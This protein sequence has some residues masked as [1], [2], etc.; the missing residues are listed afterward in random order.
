MV[1]TLVGVYVVT[2][3]GHEAASSSSNENSS[4]TIME[5]ITTE[6]YV[7]ELL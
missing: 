4:K 1:E 3:M 7:G 6:R 5:E 2:K